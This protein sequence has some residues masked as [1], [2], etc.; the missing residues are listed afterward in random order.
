MIPL[1]IGY[2]LLTVCAAIIIRPNDRNLQ[3]RG[4]Y[5][6]VEASN[7]VRFDLPSFGITIGV[8]DTTNVKLLLKAYRDV[9]VPN[10]LWVYI[11]GIR[12]SQ[13]ID[14]SSFLND[15]LYEI[16]IA[17][18]L[19]VS[20]HTIQVSKI[21][22]ADLN[23]IVPTDN[24]LTFA[25]FVLDNGNSIPLKPISSRKIEFIGDSIMGGYC[26]LC[27]G[28]YTGQSGDL[29]WSSL[30]CDNFGADCHIVSWAG[31]GLV[32]NCCGG[33]TYMPEIF[34]RKL[35]SVPGS[36]WNYS[37]WIP[38]AV[39]INLG[40]ND[41]PSPDDP[42]FEAEFEQT[43]VQFVKNISSSYH[44]NTTFFLGCGPMSSV[45]CTNVKNVISQLAQQSPEIPVYFLDQTNV[46]NATN[47]CCGHPNTVGD[48]TIADSST[49]FLAGVLNWSYVSNLWASKV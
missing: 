32:R 10:R 34:T 18:N 42:A 36:V 13:V 19:S 37:S 15:T 31:Y 43:Y 48:V 35:L 46:L 44:L 28:D 30:T 41:N 25:G 38:D 33:T 8:V 27:E 21:T 14:T 24:Y 26:N 9:G 7:E 23:A 29:S 22:E 5:D 17:S 12:T 1:I 39:V 11:D 49:A 6:I 45:Y 40:T 4:R 3:F 2:V 47:Q 20:R 16:E